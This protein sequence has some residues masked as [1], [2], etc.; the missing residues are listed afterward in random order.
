MNETQLDG[1]CNIS[2]VSF[3]HKTLIT[4]TTL[5]PFVL[6]IAAKI[7]NTIILSTLDLPL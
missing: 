7:T 3:I 1:S 6:M 2:N 4:V 5:I